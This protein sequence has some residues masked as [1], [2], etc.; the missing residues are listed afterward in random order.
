MAR[1]ALPRRS[2]L[3]IRSTRQDVFYFGTPP[4]DRRYSD[5]GLPIWLDMGRR[6]I[7]GIPG[8]ANRGFKVADDTSGPPIDPSTGSRVPLPAGL[9]R[10]R[11]FLARR[12][13]KMAGAPL[14]GTEVCQYEATADSHFIIDRHPRAPNVGSPA[15]DPATGSDGAGDRGNGRRCHAR[16]V[17]AR[18]GILARAVWTRWPTRGRKWT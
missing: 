12:F 5:E 16:A 10:V 18:F 13:P 3:A 6:V 1:L 15:V 14:L 8:N 11:T 7:Y 2:G 4:G 9:R 17:N